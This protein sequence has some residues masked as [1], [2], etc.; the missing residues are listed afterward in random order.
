MK[1]LELIKNLNNSA[2]DFIINKSKTAEIGKYELENG[3]FVNV[4]EY[5]TKKR[6]DAKYESHKNFIDIQM[7][8][9]GT[10][11]IAV[12]PIEK[13]IPCDEYN[14]T[15]DVIHYQHNDECTDFVLSD[16]DF[17]ILPPEDVHMPGVC[18]NEPS[19]V[20]KLVFKIPVNK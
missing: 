12:T 3:A 14:E 16:G 6:I 1:N 17:L 8:L 18:V 7:I 20:R 5:E 19:K 2:Y 10:E 9:S 13:M 15:K 11:L 4:Q